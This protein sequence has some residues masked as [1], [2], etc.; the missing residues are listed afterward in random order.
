L[1]D[2]F[3]DKPVPPSVET[4]LFGSVSPVS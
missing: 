1:K 3:P 2:S 4:L